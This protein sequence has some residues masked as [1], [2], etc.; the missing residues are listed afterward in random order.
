MM[1][2]GLLAFCGCSPDAV[3]FVPGKTEIVI[4]EDAPKSVQFAA[5]ELKTFL[6][7]V[8]GAEVPII[9]ALTGGKSAIV[10]GENEWSQSAGL[11]PSKL[12]RD[13]FCAQAQ[14]GRVYIAGVDDPKADFAERIKTGRLSG[15]PGNIRDGERGTLFGVY[16]FLERYC[17]CRFYF[18]GELGEVIPLKRRVTV[19]CG[20]FSLSPAF[21]V[22]DVYLSGDGKWPGEKSVGERHS[23]KCLIWLR[24]RLQ[25]ESIPCCHGMNDFQLSD[26][27]G[28]THPEWFYLAKNPNTGK[29]ARTSG[30]GSA[31]YGV[32][33]HLCFTNDEMWNQV[34]TDICAYFNGQDPAKLGIKRI[35]CSD[36]AGWGPNLSGRFVDVMAQDGMQECHCGKCQQAYDK[37]LGASGYASEL[38]WGKTAALAKRL[39][40]TGYPAIVTQM[41]YSP[42]R[43]IPKCDIPSNVWVMV[44]Q[45]GPWCV[46]NPADFAQ[47][48]ATVKAWSEKLG[49]KVWMWTYPAKHPEFELGIKGVPDYAPRAWHRYY[50]DMSE[51][52]MGAFSESECENS[53]LHYMNYYVYSKLAWDPGL[54]IDALL[55]EHYELM[56]GSGAMPMQEA[57][58]LFETKWIREIAGNTVDTP[59]G[60]QPQ[61]PSESELWTR[62]WG[63][64]EIARAV[65]LFDAAAAAVPAGS[66]EARRIAF[67]RENFLDPLVAE[68]AAKGNAMDVAK[69]RARRA[70]HP[71]KNLLENGVF[72]PNGGGWDP[73]SGPDGYDPATF[74]SAPA[75]F[76]VSN[77]D[78]KG[79]SCCTQKMTGKFKD[80]TTY[81][82][83]FF[84]KLDGVKRLQRVGHSCWA[85][86]YYDTW[87]CLPGGGQT[88]GFLLGT[89][90]WFYY[91]GTFKTG[92]R[93]ADAKADPYV[94]WGFNGNVSGTAWVD[95]I[96]L[97]E[98]K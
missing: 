9:N 19:P 41:A 54:D 63:L 25:T 98:V 34:Y 2:F 97:E 30:V 46:G 28:Q 14:D 16:E 85:I 82:I 24:L 45:G 74:V 13:G 42:Y 17:G 48:K 11:D 52:S 65:S 75:S 33:G 59:L 50:K 77:P 39:A 44:A 91:E 64:K 79:W 6:S 37:S 38:I 89:S 43:A 21:T 1:G 90:D 84:A 10:L 18:P 92:K 35:W 78:G 4:A 73:P 93:A 96:V 32:K 5:G 49:H 80:D 36:D 94:S 22:R 27:F 29:F 70:A 66:L 71:P 7:K 62:V 51:W 68:G 72:D 86:N 23:A 88:G 53:I 12:P 61:A 57:F 8:L 87:H 31:T 47:Q 67:M 15:K 3:T 95:D 83:S 81:R 26:R 58:E 40:D 55:K 60:P 76:R 69:A 56:Y 20:K